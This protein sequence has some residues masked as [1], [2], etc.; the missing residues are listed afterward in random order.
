MPAYYAIRNLLD[1]HFYFSITLEKDFKGFN[2]IKY[3]EPPEN[4]TNHHNFI[5]SLDAER[6]FEH[7]SD[8]EEGFRR[9][10]IREPSRYLLFLWLFNER[11]NKQR[12][13]S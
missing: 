10:G 1:K 8:L 11:I 3:N 7:F 6:K 5:R 9:N 13:L 4:N 2:E 12:Y